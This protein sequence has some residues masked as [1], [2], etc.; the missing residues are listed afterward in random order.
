MGH[1]TS[2]RKSHSSA[3]EV[4]LL[5]VK[6]PEVPPSQV[7][8]GVGC[9]QDANTSLQMLN[10]PA[11]EGPPRSLWGQPREDPAHGYSLLPEKSPKHGK[12]HCWSIQPLSVIRPQR[13]YINSQKKKSAERNTTGDLGIG[14]QMQDSH[15]AAN[16]EPALYYEGLRNYLRGMIQPRR[17]CEIMFRSKCFTIHFTTYQKNINTAL[18]SP[19]PPAE[20]ESPPTS[21]PSHG[22]LRHT[23]PLGQGGQLESRT[24][25]EFRAMLKMEPVSSWDRRGKFWERRVMLITQ[26]A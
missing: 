25:E 8:E 21:E 1:W 9:S 19:C 14:N 12:F 15:D 22:L 7:A 2:Q 18:S 17:E 4:L 10:S 13:H 11:R 23:R 3:S 26:T 5:L 24:N 20:L 6:T 16:S